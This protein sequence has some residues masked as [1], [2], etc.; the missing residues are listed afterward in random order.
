MCRE[1]SHRIDSRSPSPYLAQN[2][3]RCPGSRAL[4]CK[5]VLP[6]SVGWRLL[7]PLPQGNPDESLFDAEVGSDAADAH[8]TAHRGMSFD[9][10]ARLAAVTHPV[11]SSRILWNNRSDPDRTRGISPPAFDTLHTEIAD[12][13]PESPPLA[14]TNNWTNAAIRLILILRITN[15]SSDRGGASATG[16]FWSP[17]HFFL[18]YPTKNT[19]AIP[20][21]AYDGAPL[22]FPH[23]KKK[24]GR[25]VL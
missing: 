19:R 20:V 18:D 11:E 1:D 15:Y 10:A 4:S 14:P 24:G 6:R 2:C 12:E 9:T 23:K 17:A 16:K 7:H 13:T 5:S 25:G 21:Q 22:P 8:G 3:H